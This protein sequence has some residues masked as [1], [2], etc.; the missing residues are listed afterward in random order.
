MPA[1]KKTEADLMAEIEAL[2][3]RVK[4][5]E[6]AQGAVQ[7]TSERK[8]TGGEARQSEE[9]FRDLVEGS[10]QGVMVHRNFKFLF[11][12]ESYA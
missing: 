10:M 5:L 12:N 2:R 9:K 7:G 11:V 6:A 4:E 8:K 3:N 1:S